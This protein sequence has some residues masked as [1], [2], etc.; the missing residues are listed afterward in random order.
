MRRPPVALLAAVSTLAV[1]A[2]SLVAPATARAADP[3][4]R[5]SDPATLAEGSA[6]LLVTDSDV[7]SDLAVAAIKRITASGPAIDVY[8]AR[9]N[10]A[11]ARDMTYLA[12]DVGSDPGE[13]DIATNGTG[14]TL[15]WQRP[16]GNDAYEVVQAVSP[17]AG[18]GSS[19]LPQRLGRVSL[20]TPTPV[21]DGTRTPNGL[22]YT[23]AWIS[24]PTSATSTEVVTADYTDRGWQAAETRASYSAD[25]NGIAGAPQ[26]AV[27]DNASAILAFELEKDGASTLQ[28]V[29]RGPERAGSQWAVLPTPASGQAAAAVIDGPWS[30]DV[31]QVDAS[32]AVV[33]W[34][35]NVRDDAAVVR[36]SRISLFS[37]T[38]AQNKAVATDARVRA[39]DVAAARFGNDVVTWTGQAATSAGTAQPYAVKSLAVNVSS[40]ETAEFTIQSSRALGTP[41]LSMGMN[42]QDQA[43]VGVYRTAGTG[44]S[45]ATSYAT[46][47]TTTATLWSS[48][49]T[50]TLL[51]G[52]PN[53]YPFGL[54]M[55]VS[56]DSTV[57]P[58]AL[59]FESDS[60]SGSPIYQ[61]RA[62]QREIVPQTP[63]GPPTDVS[64]TAGNASAM[65]NWAAPADPGSSAITG[66]TVTANP[67]GQT[68]VSPRLAFCTVDGLTNETSYTFT[69]VATN[70]FGDSVAS[71]P[72]APVT[73]SAQ[74][75]PGAP[76]RPTAVPGDGEV[77]ITWRAP[78][79]P[80]TSPITAYDVTSLPAGHGC[81]TDP[82]TLT[83]T[84]EGLTNGTEYTFN[85]VAV[86][87]VGPGFASRS[88]AVTP[89]PEAAKPLAPS[90]LIVKAKKK[91]KA[92]V[93]W[94]AS[95]STTVGSYV[96]SVR[97][98]GGSWKRSDVGDVLKKTYRL[99][100]GKRACY[101]VAAVTTIGVRG[102]WTP[103]KCVVGKR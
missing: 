65:V 24:A 77:T 15:V 100:A 60:A 49:I 56:S 7:A 88:N 84:I 17:N 52:A 38:V 19:T 42:G 80:G 59:W 92:L 40:S 69:V 68:C 72:S 57:Q 47:G 45:L 55:L 50:E 34:T 61:V 48:P 70:E 87:A 28:T 91:R 51:G 44:F 1:A 43:W 31:A 54:T 85:V 74:R 99:S 8:Y 33:G 2:T 94:N 79:D 23:A 96:V 3:D 36:Y 32:S 10:R 73:P 78:L 90:N 22:R 89:S 26:V 30:I 76:I 67:G 101:R 93:R 98:A 29:T 16:S 86:N 82:D 20:V 62:S 14:W 58:R 53:L 18:G 71:A 66:Y 12:A 83:C 81:A 6:A 103:N 95:E 64:A 41:L 9:A 37:D 27:S 75:A 46:T 25:V 13:P 63:P 5:W 11:W 102:D 97:K 4:Y 21:V 39:L 35:R